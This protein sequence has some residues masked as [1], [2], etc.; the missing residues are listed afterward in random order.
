MVMGEPLVLWRDED[1]AAHAWRDLC[2]HRGAKLSQGRVADN[3]LVCPYHAWTYDSSGKCTKIP[4]HPGIAIPAKAKA[5]AYH[6]R[7][8]VGMIWVCLDEPEGEPP[9]A[10]WFGREGFQVVPAGPYEFNAVATR[11]MEN[12]FDVAHLCIVHDGILGTPEFPEIEKYE[13]HVGEDGIF[14]PAVKITQPAQMGQGE[15]RVA[16]FDYHIFNPLTVQLKEGPQVD[17]GGLGYAVWF[18]VTPV[19]QK[20]SLGW[21]W[22][23]YNIP[24]LDPEE[25]RRLEDEIL[26]QDIPI[27]EGQRPELLP[28]DLREE[29]HLVSDRTAIAYRKWIRELGMR[30][31]TA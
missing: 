26:S 28:T 13:V 19:S 9:P 29:L 8:S 16:Q 7:E 21:I 22:L 18:T 20:K 5:E 25:A 12:F 15:P 23:I 1:G 17:Q 6:C 2:I 31:G 10:L 3:C 11:A 4:A 27:V 30:F 14:V 24:G